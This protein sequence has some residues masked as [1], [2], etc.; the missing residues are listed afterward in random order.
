[1]GRKSLPESSPI[2]LGG[3]SVLKLVTDA[4]NLSRWNP[5]LAIKF[6]EIS[7]VKAINPIQIKEWN[8]AAKDI[9]NTITSIESQS[10]Y[11]ETEYWKNTKPCK[12]RLMEEEMTLEDYVALNQFSNSK[13]I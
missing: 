3:E 5:T 8:L 1:M 12:L 9:N 13:S 6:M 7:Y 10:S 11:N 2:F 4:R